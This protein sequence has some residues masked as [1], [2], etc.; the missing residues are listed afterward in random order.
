M[1]TPDVIYLIDMGDEIA[2]SYDT[3]QG[4]DYE[5]D[6]SI[7]YIKATPKALAAPDMLE[8]LKV[9]DYILEKGLINL[10]QGE[11]EHARQLQRAAIKKAGGL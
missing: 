7:K 3:N 1:E 5:P 6:D 2:W 8:A 11:F 10:Q 9:M 4:S